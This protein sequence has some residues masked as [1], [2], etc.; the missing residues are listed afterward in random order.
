MKLTYRYINVCVIF[1]FL[2]FTAGATTA[3]RKVDSLK[4]TLT[5]AAEDTIKART[6]IQISKLTPCEASSQ[7][8]DFATAALALS[9]RLNWSEGIYESYLRLGSI[10]EHCI[11]NT[12]STLKYYNK[13]REIAQNDYPPGQIKAL[14]CIAIVY[15][16]ATLYTK[17]I[18]YFRQILAANGKVV[19]NIGAFSNMGA[20]YAHLGMYTYALM[21]YDSALTNFDRLPREYDASVKTQQ[22]CALL[23][24]KGDIYIATSQYDQ[25][26]A[27]YSKALQM[28]QAT[29][30]QYIQALALT[31]IGKTQKEQKNYNGAVATYLRA[32]T[33]IPS[34]KRSTSDILAHLS[35]TFLETGNADKARIYIDSALSIAVSDNYLELLPALY[36][37]NG[38]IYTAQKKYN[39]AISYLRKAVALC[40]ENCVITNER[41]AWQAL[42]HTYTAMGKPAE[43]FDAYKKYVALTDSIYNSEKANELT[44]IDLLS[45]FNR[46]KQAAAAINAIK[47]QKQKIATY[48]AIGGLLAV[49]L[50]AFFIY[51]SYDHQRKANIAISRANEIMNDE[52]QRSEALLLN[53]LPA[54]VAQELKDKGNVDARLF[55]HVS[56]MFTD[57]VNF[58]EAGE[59]MSPQELVAELHTCF[60]AFDRIMGRY[61]IEKIKTVGDAYVAASG[62][63]YPRAGHAADLIKAAMECRDYMVARKLQVGDSTFAMRIG[64]NSGPVVAGIVGAKK[65]AYDIWGDTVNTAARMEQHSEPGKINI[66][67]STYDLVNDQFTCT[68]RGPIDA[69]HKGKMN[70]YFVEG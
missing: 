5:T 9:F 11:K 39:E 36:V 48:S 53:I 66:S 49:L 23:I 30:D 20:I 40:M 46:E 3:E 22:V 52:K 34:D 62:V 33:L 61:N 4:R 63:P 54:N 41:D 14:N 70:M 25:A 2:G 59:R 37:I 7:Q 28:A 27:C 35:N 60:M 24:S 1:I 69:K 44:R 21:A 8:L 12:D 58:T 15:K 6:L 16:N 17:A 45:Q 31:G 56:V 64:I 26:S 47:M 18:D 13:S 29:G 68:D 57:F 65:F 50:I 67:Q 32:L 43:A 19:D 38:R 51:R 42:S 10:Y 55:E